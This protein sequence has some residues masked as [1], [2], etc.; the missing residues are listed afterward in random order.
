MTSLPFSVEGRRKTGRR[1]L[2]PQVEH[3]GILL[4]AAVAAHLPNRWKADPARVR[5]RNGLLVV[6][7]V[8]LLIA[9]GVSV[10][11]GSRWAFRGL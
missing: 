7:G 6:V 3:M 11:Q 10:L 5:Y 2:R 8:V 9:V 1:P 4:L